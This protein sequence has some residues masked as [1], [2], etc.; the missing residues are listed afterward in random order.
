MVRMH[1]LKLEVKIN[2]TYYRDVV[3]RQMLL[4]DIRAAAEG[5]FSLFVYMN[6][7]VYC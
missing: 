4:S 1:R 5:S 2:A 3:L 7:I 6:L